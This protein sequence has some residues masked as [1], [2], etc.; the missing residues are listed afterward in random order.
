MSMLGPINVKQKKNMNIKYCFSITSCIIILLILVGCSD[1]IITNNNPNK[2]YDSDIPKG[3]I[4]IDCDESKNFTY[5]A[6]IIV[7]RLDGNEAYQSLQYRIKIT[8][9]TD[10]IYENVRATGFI[11]EELK[12]IIEVDTYM[13]FGT[14]RT[15]GVTINKND[16]AHKGLIIGRTTWIPNNINADKL[17]YYLT[18]TVRVKT[19]WNTGQ[20]YVSITPENFIQP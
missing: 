12:D 2:I 15:N 20:E 8:P 3:T 13:V 6:E 9:K 17:D 10:L 4:F 11:H 18:K 1:L 16:K 14:T 7:G 19:I 5:E